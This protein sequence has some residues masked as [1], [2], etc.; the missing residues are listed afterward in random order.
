MIK[1]KKTDVTT[2]KYKN[3]KDK[4]GGYLLLLGP[5]SAEVNLL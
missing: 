3:L 1:L 4:N 5:R 2:K